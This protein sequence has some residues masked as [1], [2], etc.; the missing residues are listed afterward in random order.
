MCV[1][2][3]QY[4]RMFNKIVLLLEKKKKTFVSMSEKGCRKLVNFSL[5][6]TISKAM[7]YQHPQSFLE[8]LIFLLVLLTISS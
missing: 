1:V 3:N 6:W 8:N 5:I 2:Q 4:V 7:L